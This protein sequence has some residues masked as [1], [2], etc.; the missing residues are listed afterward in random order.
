LR[1]PSPWPVSCEL[2]QAPA[3]SANGAASIPRRDGIFA[4]PYTSAS[5]GRAPAA[6]PSCRAAHVGTSPAAVVRL[7]LQRRADADEDVAAGVGC[8]AGAGCAA[9]H[10]CGAPPLL[11]AATCCADRVGKVAAASCG[12]VLDAEPS[13]APALPLSSSSS[14]PSSTRITSSASSDPRAPVSATAGHAELACGCMLLAPGPERFEPPCSIRRMSELRSRRRF[15]PIVTA[16]PVPHPLAPSARLFCA[17]APCARLVGA[18]A[19]S[20][21]DVRLVAARQSQP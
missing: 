20:V 7:P 9:A 12:G 1:T 13:P 8:A 19:P 5:E 18:A 21:A 10:A 16:A 11:P 14:S 15:T 17:A 2:P 6:S 3:A 4:S